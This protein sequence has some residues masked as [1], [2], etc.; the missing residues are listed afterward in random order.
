MSPAALRPAVS[1]AILSCLALGVSGCGKKEAPSAPAEPPATVKETPPAATLSASQWTDAR[2]D[3]LSPTGETIGR[4]EFRDGL[5]GV[6]MRV[7]LSALAPGWHGIHLHMVGDCSDGAQGFKASGGHIN[8]DNV[9]H[10]LLNPNGAHRADIPNLFADG[11]GNAEME[12]FRADINLKPSEEGAAIN[13]PYPLLD[14]DGF[15]V[16]V[17]A[18]PDDHATQPIGGSGDRVACAAFKG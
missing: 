2:A 6:L 3:F 7:E 18:N 14:D 16:V 9:E 4:V 12:I 10:G 11:A 17:H 5:G 8:P 13:G 15:A 1:M